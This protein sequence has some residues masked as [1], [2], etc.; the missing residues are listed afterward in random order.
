[1]LSKEYELFK[2]KAS[3]KKSTDMIIDMFDAAKV[4]L[5]L[6]YSHSNGYDL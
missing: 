4:R 3:I 5:F 6:A 2:K 1:M